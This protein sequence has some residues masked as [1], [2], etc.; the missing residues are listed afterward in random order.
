MSDQTT[1]RPIRIH[2][3]L[4]DLPE[5]W[6]FDYRE[7]GSLGFVSIRL[8]YKGQGLGHVRFSPALQMGHPDRVGRQGWI[9]CF[10]GEETHHDRLC[11]ALDALAAHA[12]LEA[13]LPVCEP[14][15]GPDRVPVDLTLYEGMDPKTW[16]EV[17]KER[18]RQV[19]RWGGNRRLPL[20][21]A[22]LS[23]VASALEDLARDQMG[24]G[25]ISFASILAEEVGEAL[26]ETD[27]QRMRVELL[28]VAAV[29]IA[30][31]E[32][33]RDEILPEADE[34]SRRRVEGPDPKVADWP[35]SW[36]KDLR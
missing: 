34:S 4:P 10:R 26:R 24:R 31:L 5:R 16:A 20:G 7:R 14:S 19:M 3:P 30:A 9:C 18:H 22:D 32:E 1:M 25:V 11:T 35:I 23:M 12:W 15:E 28:Q 21:D 6:S 33:G 2:E 36:P 17:A 8:I 27:P 29:C 13:P